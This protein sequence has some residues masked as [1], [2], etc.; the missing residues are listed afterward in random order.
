MKKN[1]L[2]KMLALAFAATFAVPTVSMQTASADG[3]AYVIRDYSQY[4]STANF[5]VG[6]FFAPDLT[7]AAEV[8]M[9]QNSGLDFI[10][11]NGNNTV[12]GG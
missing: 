9:L 8:E 2:N 1:I 3:K 10:C 5:M 11:L 4:A 7:N 6:G 12:S